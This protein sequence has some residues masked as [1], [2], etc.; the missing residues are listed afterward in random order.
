VPRLAPNRGTLSPTLPPPSSGDHAQTCGSVQGCDVLGRTSACVL[1]DLVRHCGWRR[2]TVGGCGR[3]TAPPPD[4]D[5]RRPLLGLVG[6]GLPMTAGQDGQLSMQTKTR[7]GRC[8]SSRWKVFACAAGREPQASVGEAL[9]DRDSVWV[10]R[11]RSGANAENADIDR[12]SVVRTPRAACDCG[13]CR[14]PWSLPRGAD[15][16]AKPYSADE[17]ALVSSGRIGQ[18][19]DACRDLCL[20]FLA[21][22]N[23]SVPTFALQ[24]GAW[25]VT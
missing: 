8:H 4:T 21:S 13:R 19:R 10:G 6:Q 14:T 17:M 22:R 25:C 9:I 23:P 12:P 20:R 16:G 18:C 15:F 7:K 3:R 24:G 1:Q 5:G 11:T 2:G